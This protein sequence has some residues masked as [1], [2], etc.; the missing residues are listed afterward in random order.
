MYNQ[1]MARTADPL[2][3][4]IPGLWSTKRWL[5]KSLYRGLNKILIS[6]NHQGTKELPRRKSQYKMT[7]IFA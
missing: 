4:R 2:A 1:M 7:K 3:K 5:F 6:K